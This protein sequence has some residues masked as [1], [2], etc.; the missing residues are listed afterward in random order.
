MEAKTIVNRYPLYLKLRRSPQY[1]RMDVLIDHD[2]VE[3]LKCDLCGRDMVYEGYGRDLD[4]GIIYRYAFACAT[5][6]NTP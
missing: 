6:V 3:T 5:S 1:I 4:W 2:V